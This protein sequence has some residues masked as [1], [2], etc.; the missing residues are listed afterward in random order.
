MTVT[1]ADIENNAQ[2]IAD[3]VN[4]ASPLKI[5]AFTGATTP[6]AGTDILTSIQSGVNKQLSLEQLTNA[7]APK[8]EMIHIDGD[9]TFWIEGTSISAEGFGALTMWA[10]VLSGATATL[11]RQDTAANTSKP[12][13]ARIVC[14]AADDFCGIVQT[15]EGNFVSNKTIA[16]FIEA[17][18]T[19]N[20]PTSMRFDVAN[21]ALSISYGN[22][23]ASGFT[24]NFEW[25]RFD[26]TVTANDQIDLSYALRNPNNETWDLDINKIRIIETNDLS[27]GI[28]PDW[29][30]EDEDSIKMRNKAD[31]YFERRALGSDDETA[32]GSGSIISATRADFYVSYKPKRKN[33]L[34]GAFSNLEV[35]APGVNYAVSAINAGSSYSINS[36]RIQVDITGA[37]ANRATLRTSAADGYLDFD[38]R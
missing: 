25:Y 28:V 29:I 18:Y 14:T 9:L 30:K 13:F 27:T 3:L 33:P 26:I 37:S 7:V 2:A 15:L 19:T 23:T 6:M 20:A 31:W 12:Y 35:N 8:R 16:V 21:T 10:L 11:S 34:V 38:A 4:A 32:I 22:D 24:T 1:A 36:A 17:K 5:S